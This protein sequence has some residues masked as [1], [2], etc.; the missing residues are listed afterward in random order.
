[1]TLK[2]RAKKLKT[3]V[4]AVFL[5]LKSKQTPW[6]AKI[7]A[8]IVVVYA[9]S[10]VDLIPDFIPNINKINSTKTIIILSYLIL[11]L[12]IPYPLLI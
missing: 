4:P 2:E 3:D 12:L 11:F 10:P 7:V 8:V 6:Y 5:A 1:M 9:L